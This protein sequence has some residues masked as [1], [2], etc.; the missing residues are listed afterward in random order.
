[1]ELVLHHFVPH[2][3]SLFEKLLM[4]MIVVC[5]VSTVFIRI[6]HFNFFPQGFSDAVVDLPFPFLGAIAVLFLGFACAAPE[7]EATFL[8]EERTL[9]FLAAPVVFFIFLGCCFDL[10]RWSVENFSIATA[11]SFFHTANSSLYA[12]RSALAFSW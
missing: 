3:S 8:F 1:M 2:L 5:I 11:F 12:S 4:L 6:T 7:A 9:A 10:G